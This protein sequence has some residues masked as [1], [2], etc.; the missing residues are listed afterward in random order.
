MFVK[1]QNTL[2]GTVVYLLLSPFELGNECS[3]L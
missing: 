3:A 1:V 2:I